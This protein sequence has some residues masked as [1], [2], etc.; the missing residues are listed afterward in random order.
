MA[1]AAPWFLFMNHDDDPRGD[2]ASNAGMVD[3]LR[4]SCTLQ[5]RECVDAFLAVDRRHFWTEGGG[6]RDFAYAD[7]PLRSGKLHLSAPHIY[8][9]AL[10]SLM[11]LKPGMSFLNVGSGTGYFNSIVSELI[12]GMATNHGIEIW[13]ETVAHSRRRCAALGKPSI[14]FSVGNAYQLDVGVTM[15]YDRIYLGACANSRSKYLYR[16]LEV[17]GVLIGPFQAGR[18]TQQLRRV[19]RQTES[20][21]L[22]EVLGSVQFA[23]LVEPA[24]PPPPTRPP[25]PL[26]APA[27][28]TPSVAAP[29]VATGTSGA[30]T[31]AAE[32]GQ[33]AGLPGVPFTFALSERP[34]TRDRCWLY[35]PSYRR[36]VFMGLTCRPRDCYLPSLP[37]EIWVN[38]IFPLCP[39]SWF[40]PPAPLRA[41]TPLGG[42]PAAP[43][44]FAPPPRAC[45]K[46]AEGIDDSDD[47]ASTRAPSS[48][49][50]SAQVTPETEP[51]QPPADIVAEMGTIS[52]GE[53]A[54]DLDDTFSPQPGT[55]FEVFDNGQRHA[56]GMQGDPDDMDTDFDFDGPRLAVPSRMV[57]QM[58]AATMRRRRRARPDV[59]SEDSDEEGMADAERSEATGMEAADSDAEMAEG[60][61]PEADEEDD[62]LMML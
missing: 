46:K 40:E 54:M 37:A 25:P 26:V 49:A 19:V 57:Q 32:D 43:P 17:G 58:L 60:E 39:R 48:A 13:P 52:A 53:P 62:D 34:W 20:H 16:L 35:P 29:A 61:D 42:E 22:V 47:G 14:E 24:P 31:P 1:D 51:S 44:A 55:L 59:D 30:A 3:G 50:S 4:H 23:S 15:R 33:P 7:T 6:E 27:A 41:P 10:E 5:S 56:I 12:G 38:H 36:T 18:S 8:A 21:F 2:A 28:A 9:K 45:T 11:P